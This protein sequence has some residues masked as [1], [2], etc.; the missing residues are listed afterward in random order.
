[1]TQSLVRRLFA[2]ALCASACQRAPSAPCFTTRS[3]GAGAGCAFNHQCAS[4]VCSAG[5]CAAPSCGDGVQN[6]DE[7]GV[8]C[9]GACG[10]NCG[11]GAPCGSG[12]DC[13]F[14]VCASG[15][16]APPASGP[17]PTGPAAALIAPDGG[18]VSAVTAEHVRVTIDF[19][20]GAVKTSLSVKVTPL[21]PEAGQWARV[22]L[23]PAGATFLQPALVTFALPSAV[24]AAAAGVYFGSADEPLLIAST[25]SASAVT[26]PLASFG[27]PSGSSL[28][29]GAF[30]DYT[31]G[32]FLAASPLFT[33][34][35][36]LAMAERLLAGG[37]SETRSTPTPPASRS[38]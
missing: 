18:T 13:A 26:A 1:M 35:E 6:G 16:C 10:A 3:C 5:A 15:K 33:L 36:K 4:R 22:Q 28:P 29:P 31:P 21:A 32:S 27:F 7:R 2:L 34:D 20:A 9:G 30:G 38:G 19:P 8:D 25:S 12:G 37:P 17:A 11:L 23:E 14:G 24:S